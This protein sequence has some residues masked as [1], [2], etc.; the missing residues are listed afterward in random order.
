MKILFLLF[1]FSINIITITAQ[2]IISSNQTG[3]KQQFIKQKPAHFY[4]SIQTKDDSIKTYDLDLLESENVIVEF[5]PAPMFKANK[6][7][8]QKRS[9]SDYQNL[10]DRFSNDLSALTNSLSK[11]AR[12]LKSAPVIK[13]KFYK[14]FTGVNV[15]IPKGLLASISSLSYVKNIY[16][17]NRV[18]PLENDDLSKY[19][20]SLKIGSFSNVKG[21]SIVVG[22]IDTGID[23]M[24]PELGGGFG[25]GY[26]VIGGYDIINGDDDPMDDIGHGT[27]V[28][29]IIA[30]DG[31]SLE[32]VAPHAKLMAFKIFSPTKETFDAEVIA[33]IERAIDPNNDGNF[34]D[35][36]DV[37]NM[38]LGGSGDPDDPVST[39]VDNAS[40]LGIVFCVAV[41]NAGSFFTISSPGNA[42]SAIGVGASDYENNIADFSSR[43]PTRKT[44][45][46]KPD[47]LAP[48]VDVYSTYLNNTFV[49]MSGT[50]MATPYIAGVC[51]LLKQLHKDWSPEKIKSVIMTTATSLSNDIMEQGAGIVNPDK[52]LNEQTTIS[53][54]SLSYGFCNTQVD[55]WIKTDT[56]LVKNNSNSSKEYSINISNPLLEVTPSNLTIGPNDSEYVYVKLTVDNS[57]IDFLQ[58]GSHSYNGDLNISDGLEQLHIPWAFVKTTR[59]FLSFDKPPAYFTITNND[60]TYSPIDAD[61][62]DDYTQA[63]L[64]IPGS[65]YNITSIFIQFNND[66]L[67]NIQSIKIVNNENVKVENSSS[68]VIN[69]EDAKNQLYFE[70]TDETG[71]ELSK[72]MNWS[73]DLSLIYPDSLQIKSFNF[74]IDSGATLSLS[75][76][77]QKFS[78]LPGEFERDYNS[79]KIYLYYHDVVKGVNSDIY[80][81]NRPDNNYITANLD[82]YHSPFINTH[83]LYFG[84][85]VDLTYLYDFPGYYASY[86]DPV[87]LNTNHWKGVLYIFP[88]KSNR[89]GFSTNIYEPLT[90]DNYPPYSWLATGMFAV[91][92]D[93]IGFY[94]LFDST[95][96]KY[97]IPNGGEIIIGKGISV[98]NSNLFYPY[99]SV[100]YAGYVKL[101]FIGQFGEY[102]YSDLENTTYKLLNS[103]DD[104]ILQG[105]FDDPRRNL[106]ALNTGNYRLEMTQSNY[107]IEK[108]RGTLS[109]NISFNKV[110][111]QDSV[112][113]P[114]T[115]TLQ[116]L[117]SKNIPST[118]LEK[119]EKA[120]ILFS[121]VN[122]SLGDSINMFVKEQNSNS[123]DTVN[124][125]YLHY[126]PQN[127]FVYSGDLSNYTD[128]DSAALDF[129]LDL[130]DGSN[131]KSEITWEPAVGIGKFVGSLEPVSVDEQKNELPVKYKLFDNYPNPFN[132]TT[133]IKYSIPEGMQR[134]VSVQLKVYDILGREVATLV[135]ET[136]A[137]GN[138]VVNFNASNLASGIYF[139]MLKAGNFVQTKKMILLR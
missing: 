29:G 107:T 98:P 91:R 10:F 105:N 122:F 18:Y 97:M 104:I 9:V 75:D 133:R 59:I 49:K 65:T 121:V 60:S 5:T 37:V 4:Y 72:K 127:G 55:V 108:E 83:K 43:G 138:Y 90:E 116:I 96:I 27:H 101:G 21:D 132:P 12:L 129:K 45:S 48:G 77:S 19:N 95:N 70:A 3:Q 36:V 34:D 74:N 110:E 7:K 80:L 50:S 85:S 32:G 136:K 8:L 13:R 68:I 73:G 56:L 44:Y 124:I 94:S 1:L 103:K 76:M 2:T 93:S 114:I 92:N 99:D 24:N 46:I 61:W 137:P 57:K 30:A 39:A 54:S 23:Y 71:T 89:Y 109:M 100:D 52:A 131:Y 31:A 47:V 41:G 58:S 64:I 42:R 33:G 28:A 16:K 20:Y 135:N 134:A 117:N 17:N 82:I 88:N 123:W 87:E 62:N 111:Q 35:K 26:K 102:R 118:L 63:E 120:N 11:N 15:E 112:S 113:P 38:S 125:K 14:L 81:M 106:D 130:A 84:K 79:H 128:F 6:N 66:T 40:E 22:E 126:N 67:Y 115:Q 139:Y 25:P 69:S 53:P 51:A 119:N 86:I 78:L